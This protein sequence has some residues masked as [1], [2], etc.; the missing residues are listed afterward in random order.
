[1]Q[2]LTDFSF[3][4]YYSSSDNPLK[5]FYIPAL[6]ASI[7]YDRSAGFFSSTS[8]AV[9]AAGVARL[10]HNGGRMR[11]LVGAD[12]NEQDVE[13]IRQGCELREC[14]TEKLLERFP[15]PQDALLKR[16]LEILAWMAATGTLEIRVVLPRDDH[17]LPIPAAQ[18]SDYYH[19]K[20]G[21]FTDAEGNRLAFTGSVNESA[22]AWLHNY[23]E[24]A[25]YRSWG[26]GASYLP[27]VMGR[28]NRLWED[29]D[30]DW[31]GLDIPSAVTQRLL[32]FKPD[33]APEFDPLETPAPE[34][35][36]DIASPA[37]P[38]ATRDKLL[39]QFVR[40]APFMPAASGIGIATAAIAPWPH[41]TRVA[42][43]VIRDYPRRAL[44]CDEVGLGKT[45][46]AGLV[47]RQL[48][49]SRARQTLPDPGP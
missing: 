20:S 13:A 24:F 40:D 25:V 2:K 14:L 22:Q 17:G 44:F 37:I 30:P 45:V 31:I 34:Q 43:E 4:I 7:Q 48:V 35:I 15:D 33:Q 38:Q 47:I 3:Q 5:D 29:K 23:E 36:D 49:L 16:R 6:S 9:A 19:P 8:L 46:E 11:L 39:I 10:I 1:M 27:A 21:I 42:D 32:Q 12:L 28:F 41:Q 18:S 26:E